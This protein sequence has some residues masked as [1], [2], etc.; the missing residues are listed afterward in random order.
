MSRSWFNPTKHHQGEQSA[1]SKGC[2]IKKHYCFLYGCCYDSILVFEL[3]QHVCGLLLV[4]TGCV[5]YRVL[6]SW[7]APIRG[8]RTE[9]R[10]IVTATRRR[11]TPH[12]PMCEREVSLGLTQPTDLERWKKIQ[13]ILCI[14]VWCNCEHHL[15]CISCF[16]FECLLVVM[17]LI[18]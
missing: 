14:R 1:I 15:H 7:V 9:Y 2:K 3:R 12:I 10:P 13:Q 18:K 6:I 8:S 11:A 5:L 4:C 16:W 17:R